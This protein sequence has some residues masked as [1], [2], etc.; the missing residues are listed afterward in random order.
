DNNQTVNL[1]KG[2]D[3][4]NATFPSTQFIFTIKHNQEKKYQIE[5][6]EK[7]QEKLLYSNTHEVT[8]PQDLLIEGHFWNPTKKEY[9]VGRIFLKKGG[10]ETNG[11]L[12]NLISLSLISEEGE[13]RA[14]NPPKQNWHGT[15]E[16]IL[17]L[18]SS[19]P[20]KE[21]ED[22]KE[23][24]PIEVAKAA[25]ER[26]H[27][28]IRPKFHGSDGHSVGPLN[29]IT[30]EKRGHLSLNLKAGKGGA[31]EDGTDGSN[32]RPGKPAQTRT[33]FLVNRIVPDC[34]SPPTNGTPGTNG[35]DG[36]NGGN[37]GNIG[38]LFLLMPSSKISFFLAPSFFSPK[39]AYKLSIEGLDLKLEAGKGGAGGKGGRG[40]KGGPAGKNITPCPSAK[41][42]KDGL[43]GKD[44][45][46]GKPGYL[47]SLCL[48]IPKI[49][50]KEIQL[51]L[52]HPTLNLKGEC[53]YEKQ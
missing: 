32:G 50:E 16:S 5:I 22:Y 45:K 20:Y 19:P 9:K 4:P 43:D 42:G 46:D 13:I 17:S 41:P 23:R 15:K 21:K 1:I 49:S 11:H 37:G 35:T 18:S 33:A 3:A 34:L 2:K 47:T 6:W 38:P 48:L 29:I 26:I 40:G 7:D 44:G 8:I 53:F 24:E 52:S 30:L 12:L 51:S 28:S 31:G 36:G 14:F 39:Q 27:Q 10:I 25:L